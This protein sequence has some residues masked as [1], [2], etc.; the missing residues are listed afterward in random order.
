V[1]A[2]HSKGGDAADAKS[3]K[4]ELNFLLK[5]HA[6]AHGDALLLEDLIMKNKVRDEAFLSGPTQPHPHVKPTKPPHGFEG[7]DRSPLTV[8]S[9]HCKGGALNP[10]P[11]PKA[12]RRRWW[13]TDPLLFPSA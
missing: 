6:D 8:G 7:G 13:A 4:K 1:C 10:P 12:G 2:A 3:A 11:D 5:E 9:A